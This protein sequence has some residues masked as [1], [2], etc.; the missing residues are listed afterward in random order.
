VPDLQ[1]PAG[2]KR[3]A[4]RWPSVAAGIVV[5][6]ALVAAAI[7]VVRSARNVRPGPAPVS[8][9]PP[10]PDTEGL[11][12]RHNLRNRLE[13]QTR[14]LSKYRPLAARSGPKLDSLAVE[15]ETILGQLRR[16][17]SRFDSLSGYRPKRALYDSIMLDYEVLRAR[18]RALARGLS[19]DG[20]DHDSL[21]AELRRLLSE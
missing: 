4:P 17:F 20:P 13:T 6:A 5:L 8:L 9:L 7:V 1:P 12:L 14:R 2:E 11:K 19:S 18:I 15:C 3:P 21:N 10:R 16:R